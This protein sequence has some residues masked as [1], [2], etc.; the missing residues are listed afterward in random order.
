VPARP[1][2]WQ[3]RPRSALPLGQISS[4]PCSYQLPRVDTPTSV[5]PLRHAA[6]EA[7]IRHIRPH[8]ADAVP[9]ASLSGE[10]AAAASCRRWQE[11]LAEIIAPA[12]K[13]RPHTVTAG[14]VGPV[15]GV[16]G[17]CPTADG[18]RGGRAGA[19]ARA[20]RAAC[21]D[22][23]TS[24]RC[25]RGHVASSDAARAG[26]VR[27]RCD[28]RRRRRPGVSAW[29]RRRRLAPRRAGVRCRAR[30]R[31]RRESRRR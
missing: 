10:A 7:P 30:F 9:R 29:V 2:R 6:R 28:R 13:A 24:D 31:R 25:T 20:G 4:A 1:T 27:N 5:G 23:S 26:P 16:F 11:N 22:A 17:G 21:R 8:V 12:V 3:A 14:R 15:F 19:A 18:R